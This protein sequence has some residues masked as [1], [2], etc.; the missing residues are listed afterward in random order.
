MASIGGRKLMNSAALDLGDR[1][2]SMVLEILDRSAPDTAVWA[3]GSRVTGGA[4]RYSDL[5]L[6]ILDDAPVSRSVRADPAEAFSE[7]DLPWRVD[8]LDWAR[9]TPEFRAI[10]A[11]T[12]V[13]LPEARTSGL[14][15]S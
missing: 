15:A 8:I 2:R 13:V 7:S 6:A 9:A 14:S 12:K 1:E 4:Q 5:D 11:Q 3:Y 10:S